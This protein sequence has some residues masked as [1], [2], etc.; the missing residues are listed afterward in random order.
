MNKSQQEEYGS[1]SETLGVMN[2][3]KTGELHRFVGGRL[4]FI[5]K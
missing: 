2:Q 1:A 3:R 4:L 5:L